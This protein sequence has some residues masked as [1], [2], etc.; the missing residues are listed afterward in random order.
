MLLQKML[1]QRLEVRG[2]FPQRGD[3]DGKEIKPMKE[4]PSKLA[5]LCHCV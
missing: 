4:I 3:M 1:D 5:L 2:P